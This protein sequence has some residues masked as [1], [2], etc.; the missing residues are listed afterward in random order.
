MGANVVV[1][2]DSWWY[3][4]NVFGEGSLL[5]NMKADPDL[6]ENIADNNPSICREMLELVVEEAGGQIPR[7]KFRAF[8]KKPNSRLWRFG[9]DGE[10]YCSTKPIAEYK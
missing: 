8:A 5:Y 2:K 6:L 1:I 3:N 10:T 9:E 4:A 7:N